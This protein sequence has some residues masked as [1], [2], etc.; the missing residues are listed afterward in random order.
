MHNMQCLSVEVHRV[1]VTNVNGKPL[2]DVRKHDAVCDVQTAGAE[3]VKGVFW[4]AHPDWQ[5]QATRDCTVCCDL[6]L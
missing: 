1:L 5:S 4:P 6:S 3:S 2:C